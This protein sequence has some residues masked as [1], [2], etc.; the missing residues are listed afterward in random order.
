MAVKCKVTLGCLGY[1][2]LVLSVFAVKREICL[3]C[4]IKTCYDSNLYASQERESFV[5]SSN[6]SI[7]PR[8]KPE[9]TKNSH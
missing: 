7:N 6:W 2:F 4:D 3:F 8:Y 5:Y 1:L 9:I